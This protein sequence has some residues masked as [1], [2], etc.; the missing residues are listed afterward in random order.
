MKIPFI[1]N[2]NKHKSEEAL[3]LTVISIL[4]PQGIFKNCITLTFLTHIIYNTS[5]SF[6][7]N[8]SPHPEE[9]TISREYQANAYNCYMQSFHSAFTTP[10]SLKQPTARR[11]T[12]VPG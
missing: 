3:P 12:S 6:S 11:D 8:V 7:A 5:A 1:L 10:F 4:N 2:I 9:S